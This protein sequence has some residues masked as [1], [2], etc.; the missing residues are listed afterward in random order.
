M[1]DVEQGGVYVFSWKDALGQMTNEIY[2][3]RHIRR[4]RDDFG[5]GVH[6]PHPRHLPTKHMPDHTQLGSFDNRHEG[7]GNATRVPETPD[8]TRPGGQKTAPADPYL[9]GKTAAPRPSS[10]TGIPARGPPPFVL[11]IGFLT[12]TKLPKVLEEHQILLDQ[13]GPIIQ[14]IKELKDTVPDDSEAA[15]IQ[16]RKLQRLMQHF[17]NVRERTRELEMAL[18]L[19]NPEPSANDLAS[20]RRASWPTLSKASA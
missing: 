17:Q 19:V 18:D 6:L 9:Y 15:N 10:A 8:D 20:L 1:P 11:G 4:K 2:Y 12:P 3:Q 14:A 13:V 5:A 7:Y 16:E